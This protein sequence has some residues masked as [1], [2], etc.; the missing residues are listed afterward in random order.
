M[1][2]CM[3]DSAHDKEHVYRVLSIGLDIACGL[4][5]ADKDVVIAAC[6]LHDVG[7]KEQFDDPRL[8]HALVGAEKARGFLLGNGFSPDF[9]DAVAGCIAA[10]R[11]RSGRD[12]ESIE[13]K[14]LYD[15]DKVDVTGAMG[16]ARTLMYQGHEGIHLYHIGAGGLPS[17][18]AEDKA[19]SF[20]REYRRKLKGLYE[21]F[22]TQRGL[23]LALERRQAAQAF[24]QSLLLES[25]GAYQSQGLL[26]KLLKE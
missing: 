4:P 20:F 1:L 16:V 11:F 10:H 24:Y 5:E 7:R 6:L 25:R 18:G 17:D 22:Y 13:E 26:N 19:P 9:A 8:C 23:S 15:A 3:G 2:R 14:I 21:G 12:P